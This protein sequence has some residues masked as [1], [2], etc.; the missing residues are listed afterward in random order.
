MIIVHGALKTAKRIYA[1]T[2]FD[3]LVLDGNDLRDLPLS[4]RKAN[5][6]RLL[7]RNCMQPCYRGRDA[8]LAFILITRLAFRNCEQ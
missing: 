4:M 5:L 8:A 3:V 2:A 7:A 6:A 1:N